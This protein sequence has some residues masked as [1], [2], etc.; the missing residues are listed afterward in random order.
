MVPGSEDAGG[1]PV[2]E[3][4][5][6]PEKPSVSDV[7]PLPS[8]QP[9]GFSLHAS[10]G[11][12][13]DYLRIGAAIFA[14]LGILGIIVFSFTD[15]SRRILPMEDRYLNV[16]IPHSAEGTKP[17][18]LVE[19]QDEMEGNRISVSGRMRNDSLQTVENVV[20]VITARETTGRFP[21]T[22]E[23]PVQPAVL[24][25]DHEGTFSVSVT[26]RQRPDNYSIRFRLEN[27][28]FVPHSD[29]RTYSL[30]IIPRQ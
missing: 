25:P 22:V 7:P 29:E 30:E 20:A 18:A 16:L 26:L 8:N 24:E 11:S 6:L 2:P 1:T 3:E 17:F 23:V 28:P 13:R 27:G 10:R 9:G 4:D 5:P 14:G 21:E 15:L 19:L 12:E